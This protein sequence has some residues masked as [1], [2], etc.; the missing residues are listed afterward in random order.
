VKTILIHDWLVTFGG[1]ERVLDAIFSLYPSPICTLIERK[2]VFKQAS[3]AQAKIMTSFIQNL[4]FAL[5]GYRN[6]LPFFPKAIERFDVGEYDVVLSSSHA[7]AKGVVIQDGQM[8]ICYCHTPM[9]Y[10]WDLQEQYMSDLS[11]VKEVLARWMLAY[12]RK[13]D[14]NSASRVTHYIGN[15]HYVAERIKRVYGRDAAVIYPPVQVDEIRVQE[16]KS[17]YYLAMSRLVPYKRI[18]LIVEAFA[19]LP[20]KKLLVIGDGPEMEKIKRLAGKNVELLG[21]QSDE[22]VRE[23]LGKAKALIFAADEDFG[24][25]P[26]EAQAAGTPVVAYGK[27]GVLETVID[28][29]TGVFFEE[30]TVS[31][32]IGALEKFDKLLFNPQ[33]IRQNAERFN[34]ARFKREFKQFVEKRWEEFCENHHFGRR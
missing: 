5:K 4:P 12:L 3:F 28:G 14:V 21:Y 10:A 27:G 26:V 11:G 7:V 2:G 30:Q 16:E 9:R 31:S 32:L 6:Y 15:S 34:G 13:W 33:V 1:A 23:Y 24:I 8:H 29:K 17:H 22:K 25:V 20:D 18:D 19:H